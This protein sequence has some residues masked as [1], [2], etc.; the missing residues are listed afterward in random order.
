MYLIKSQKKQ[1]T[2]H[3]KEEKM[4]VLFYYAE[5]QEDKK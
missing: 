5:Y 4:Q 2:T 1:F 3:K